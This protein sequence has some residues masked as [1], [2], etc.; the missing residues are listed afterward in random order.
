[1]S[2]MK[3]KGAIVITGAVENDVAIINDLV[4]ERKCPKCGQLIKVGANVLLT[5]VLNISA[6]DHAACPQCAAQI[7]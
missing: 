3:T 5:S 1:M 2:T 4:E 7:S 6:N